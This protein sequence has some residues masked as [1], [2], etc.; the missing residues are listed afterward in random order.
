MK[1]SVNTNPEGFAP[2]EFTITLETQEDVDRMYC[3]LNHSTIV[4]FLGKSTNDSSLRFPLDSLKEEHTRYW[5]E[6][7]DRLKKLN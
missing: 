4:G 5:D 1:T 6:L 3:V 7:E 2:V